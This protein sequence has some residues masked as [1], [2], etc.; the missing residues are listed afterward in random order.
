M[1]KNGEEAAPRRETGNVSEQLRTKLG[2]SP[3]RQNRLASSRECTTGCHRETIPR[4]MLISTH[5]QVLT[6]YSGG[7]ST[8]HL[9]PLQHTSA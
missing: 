1:D 5:L 7:R 4:W 8:D 3:R 6:A 9:L 2:T